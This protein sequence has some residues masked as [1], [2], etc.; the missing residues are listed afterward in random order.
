MIV[1]MRRQ[2]VYQ[3]NLDPL[4]QGTLNSI[5]NTG[6]SLGESPRKRSA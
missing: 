4:L 1:Q 6:N 2:L 5:A 3:G